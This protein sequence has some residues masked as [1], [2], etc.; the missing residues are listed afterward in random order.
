MLLAL[1]VLAYVLLSGLFDLCIGLKTA[2]VNWTNE[3]TPIKQSAASMIAIF[4]S[5]GYTIA[6]AVIYFTV[7]H[8]I[9]ATFYLAIITLLP[10][11]ISAILYNW[12]RKKGVIL[13]SAL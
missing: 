7:G 5:W 9:G 2:N 11:L 4:G 13:F 10:L 12:I 1:S 6:I 8:L 3:M